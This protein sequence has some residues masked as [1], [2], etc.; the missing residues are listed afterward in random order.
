MAGALPRQTRALGRALMPCS[1]AALAAISI[2]CSFAGPRLAYRDILE[3]GS[4]LAFAGISGQHYVEMGIDLCSA[5]EARTLATHHLIRFAPSALINLANGLVG[6]MSATPDD[7]ILAYSLANLMAVLGSAFL[8]W[9]L[10]VAIRLTAAGAALG[11]GFLFLNYAVLREPFFVP[12]TTDYFALFFSM[13]SL[14]AY[15]RGSAIILFLATGAAIFTWP[16]ALLLNGA[17]LAMPWKDGSTG[18][19]VPPAVPSAPWIDRLDVAIRAGLV[20][21][22]AYLS[23]HY[24]FLDP[25]WTPHGA[26]QIDYTLAPLSTGIAVAYVAWCARC[27]SLKSLI[28]PRSFSRTGFALAMVAAISYFA[29]R[30]ML[31]HYSNQRVQVDVFYVLRYLP[32]EPAV[33][34]GLFL[35]AHVVYWGP[36]ALLFLFLLRHLAK[37][38]AGQSALHLSVALFA[39][40]FI[41][42]ESRVAIYCVPMAV[43]CLVRTLERMEITASHAALLIGLSLA[44]SRFWLPLGSARDFDRVLEFPAQWLFMQFGPWMGPSAYWLAVGQTVLVSG[45]LFWILRRRAAS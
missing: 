5:L 20:L 1:I 13:L 22:F 39:I 42:T 16:V 43:F 44:A 17:M 18:K 23:V 7:V 10:A 37:F 26:E 12:V 9:R 21:A 19:P 29:V 6:R 4:L 45:C 30:A 31:D 40:L 38:S 15:Q 24:I 34:P 32:S 3:I 41:Y 28:A 25:M 36:W 33:R 2:F 8:W 27:I 11:V 35:V 14:W